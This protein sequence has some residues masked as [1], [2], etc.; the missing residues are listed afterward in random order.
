MNQEYI[1][2]TFI[3]DVSVVFADGIP[4]HTTTYKL[5]ELDDFLNNYL[6]DAHAINDIKANILSTVYNFRD[7]TGNRQNCFIPQTVS[8]DVPPGVD[9]GLIR[10][11]NET[12]WGKDESFTQ[13]VPN[14]TFTVPGIITQ[15]EKHVLSTDSLITESL[16]GKAEALDCY[17]LQI[18]QEAVNKEKI[19]NLETLQQITK[20][21]SLDMSN[22]ED[23]KTVYSKCCDNKNAETLQKQQE[24]LI[25]EQ[26]TLIEMLRNKI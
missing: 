14:T 23:Y 15:I 22:A 4:E 19:S 7:Y 16:L 9:A 26:M 24:D 10:V 11:M 18:Q 21:Q 12:Y 3:D 17:N 25:K 2:V 1:V 5:Y 13:A 20:I 8:V 6:Q